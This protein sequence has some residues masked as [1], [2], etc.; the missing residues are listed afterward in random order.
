[1]CKSVKVTIQA[2]HTSI[3]ENV[4]FCFNNTLKVTVVHSVTGTVTMTMTGNPMF[5]EDLIKLYIQ[6]G[7]WWLRCAQKSTKYTI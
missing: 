5:I 2:L 4:E 1:M 3:S 6:G 7:V